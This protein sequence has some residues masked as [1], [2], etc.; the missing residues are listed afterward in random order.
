MTIAEAVNAQ[1]NW[2]PS[3]SGDAMLTL[4]NRQ[5]DEVFVNDTLRKIGGFAFNTETGR[6][7]RG[8]L[9]GQED[10]GAIHEAS[11]TGLA[12]EH[13][14]HDPRV[15]RFLSLDPLA[16]KFPYYSPYHFSGNSPISTVDIEGLEDVYYLGALLRGNE[17]ALFSVLTGSDVYQQAMTTFTDPTKNLGYDLVFVEDRDNRMLIPAADGQTEVV[18]SSW[19]GNSRFKSSPLGSLVDPITIN[20]VA[21]KGRGLIVVLMPNGAFEAASQSA[22]I[23]KWSPAGGH[24]KSA[25]HEI[26]SHALNDAAGLPTSPEQDHYDYHYDPTAPEYMQVRELSSPREDRIL[27]YL[28]L[29]NAARDINSINGV[30]NGRNQREA[31]YVQPMKVRNGTL[32]DRALP[33]PQPI[34]R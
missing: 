34:A 25:M 7:Y 1:Q 26:N 29:S 23:G 30:V 2:T 16:S 32:S 20:D 27:D 19:V 10:H 5:V 28:P 12:F 14:I 11:E 9:Q 13:R 24:A 3:S 8:S 31:S 6:A 33:K 15:G 18:Q 21:A 22:A 17:E 4:S